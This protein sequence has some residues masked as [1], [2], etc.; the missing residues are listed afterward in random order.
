MDALS[1]IVEARIREAIERG[2]LDRLP[3]RG[4]P[5]DLEDLS[6][7]PAEL[8]LGFKILKDAGVLPEELAL[9]EEVLSL[10]RLLAAVEDD[11]EETAGLRKRLTERRLQ[12]LIL[13]ERRL[14]GAARH[15][16]GSKIRR[17]LGL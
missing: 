12:Y 15:R 1:R 8:R 7:V 9:H 16:Y 17:K 5:I 3:G 4:K 13:R 11:G 10:E 2:E 14:H 6:R